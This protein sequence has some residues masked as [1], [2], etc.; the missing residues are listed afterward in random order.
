MPIRNI[1]GAESK[2]I[3]ADGI[4]THYY[5]AGT[6]GTPVILVHG[7][8]AGADSYGNWRELIRLF[9][10]SHHTIAIDM[11]GFGHTE[12]PLPIQREY[13]QQ[14]RVKHLV[15]FIGALEVGAVN[16]V[17]NSMGGLTSIGVAVERP[18]LVRRLVLMG[19][20]GI[21]TPISE[22]LKS[23][24]H[25]DY[26]IAGM[27][28]IVR[29]LTNPDFTVDKELLNYR[30]DVSIQDDTRAAYSATMQW[31]QQRGG[32]FCEETYIQRIS[33]KTL[34]VNGKLD[35]VVPVTSAY[36]MLELIDNSW[37][38]IIPHCGH[39]AMIEHPVDFARTALH[40][41]AQ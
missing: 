38:Y 14:G 7:G 29:G 24:M 23:I 21:R 11:A 41:L 9:A 17:G 10:G 16:L 25:Y 8:G 20:A 15:D 5:E 30:Y 39:W 18:E 28:K 35:R 19:S 22:E 26:T 27:R 40:F 1:E 34:V 31:Q 4:R 2:F 37:G 3:Q 13:T 32:L 33:Q 12:K 6:S 36:R